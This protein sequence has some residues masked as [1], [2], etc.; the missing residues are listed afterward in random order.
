MIWRDN[1]SPDFL[2][3]KAIGVVLKKN[4]FAFITQKYLRYKGVFGAFWACFVVITQIFLRYRMEAPFENHKR[5]RCCN[6]SL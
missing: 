4:N 2:S 3:S 1:G 5:R 6:P